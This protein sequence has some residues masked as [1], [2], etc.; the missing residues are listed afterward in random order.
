MNFLAHLL[1]SG[2]DP[3]VMIGN[4]I[5]DFVKGKAYENFEPEVRKGILLHREIDRFTDSHPTVLQSK[6]RLRPRYRHYAAVIVD[7][8]YDHF[9]A[10]SWP[11][12]H[13]L[14]LLE[15]TENFYQL[16]ETYQHV[17]PENTQ[18]MLQ[19]MRDDNWLYQYRLIEGI[20]QALTGM[21]SR[22]PYDSHMELAAGDLRADYLSYQQEFSRFFIELQVQCQQFL[23]NFPD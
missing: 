22:T 19:Y 13:H 11:Q 3:P 9:L 2:D 20:Q 10:V 14:P 18:R 7:V 15:Y 8:F 21:A 1:L 17:L 23:K 4:F 5:G 12:Y 6:Q 16:A